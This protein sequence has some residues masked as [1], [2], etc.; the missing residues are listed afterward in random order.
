[1][2]V[3]TKLYLKERFKSGETPLASDWIDLFDSLAFLLD[4]N[5]TDLVSDALQSGVISVPLPNV[6]PPLNG[7]KLTNISPPAWLEESSIVIYASPEQINI[8]GANKTSDYLPGRFLRL[9][10]SGTFEYNEVSSST[11]DAQSDVTTINLRDCLSGTG[12]S[13]MSYGFI[14]PFGLGGSVSPKTVGASPDWTR[15]VYLSS[16]LEAGVYTLPDAQFID[17]SQ[18]LISFPNNLSSQVILRPES[19]D[20]GGFNLD[21]N[22]S[23]HD[24]ITLRLLGD[25]F[26]PASDLAGTLARKP[27]IFYA[28]DF[29]LDLTP[30]KQATILNFEQQLVHRVVQNQILHFGDGRIDFYHMAS[31][32][33]LLTC[34]M[35]TASANKRIRVE[36][37]VYL[38]TTG[39]KRTVNFDNISTPSNTSE[40]VIPLAQILLDSDLSLDTQGRIEVRRLVASSSEH[41]GGLLFLKGEVNNV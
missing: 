2:P 16:L 11:Y 31:H 35:D 26:Q 14:L 17:G 24:A 3:K 10:I 4:D 30:D 32:D 38:K 23:A 18:I 25:T 34:R 36:V 22:L 37:S 15:H 21:L 6:L 39:L 12:L 5:I 40:F 8:L 28:S 19:H 33:L 9:T 41:P 29:R 1:M 7:S 13:A 27:Q 20:D